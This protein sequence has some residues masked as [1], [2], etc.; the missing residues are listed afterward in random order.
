TG[1]DSAELDGL[2]RGRPLPVDPDIAPPMPA[3][4]RS[5]PGEVYELGAHRLLCGDA[6]DPEQVETLLV[7]EQPLLLVTDPPYGVELDMEWRD[8]AGFNDK[9]RFQGTA[10]PGEKNPAE[11]SYLRKR[12]G[13]SNRSISG[14]TRADWSEAF[15]LVRS[16]KVAYVW[17]ADRYTPQ[18]GEG[19]RRLGVE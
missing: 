7:G 4:P 16:R 8:R 15:A 2:L 1:F 14:D 6:T 3:K 19:L 9:G 18:V 11:P 13:H 12:E 5:K 17:H 10:T